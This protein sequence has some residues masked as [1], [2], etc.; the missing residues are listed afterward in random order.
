MEFRRYIEKLLKKHRFRFKKLKSVEF[1]GS[2]KYDEYFK[3]HDKDIN[4]EMI[5]TFVGQNNFDATKD[6]LVQIFQCSF[7]D[8]IHYVF[9]YDPL[10]FYQGETVLKVI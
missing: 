7:E 9:V 10:E 3:C 8:S 2:I 4:G 1:I 6:N 5:K